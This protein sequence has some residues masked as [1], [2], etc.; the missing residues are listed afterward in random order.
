M[1]RQIAIASQKGGVGKTTTATNLAASLGFAGRRCLVVDLDPQANGTTGLGIEHPSEGGAAEVLFRPDRVRDAI[2]ENVC[3]GVDL[4]PSGGPMRAAE[5]RLSQAFGGRG[6]LA[7]A[8]ARL[9]DKYDYVLVDCPPSLGAL[10]TAALLACG[11]I[12][13]PMQCEFFALEGLAQVASAVSALQKGRNPSLRIE[14]I[15]FTMFDTSAQIGYEVMEDVGKHFGHAVYRT[16]IPRDPAIT[17][18]PSHGVSV[19]DY[20]LRSRGAR[21]YLELAKEVLARG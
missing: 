9:G 16:A 17:E 6:P 2:I 19:L 1:T 5:A 12:L 11:S 20:D 15:L 3:E 21:A 8:F 7:N 10:T 13:V 14:G 18:A 4:I